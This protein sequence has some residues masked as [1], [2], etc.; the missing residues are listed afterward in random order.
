MTIHPTAVVDSGAEIDGSATIGPYSIVEK[1]AVVG[2]DCVIGPH[3]IISGATTMGAR[4]TV[5][6]F[7]N[8]GTPP[9]DLTYHNEATRLTIGDDNQIRE[10]VSIHRG[11]PGGHGVT[12]IG[13]G[14]LIMAYA[15]I[16]HDCVV[17]NNVILVN[18]VTLGGHVEIGDRATIGGLSAVHQFTRVGD[19]SYIGGMSGISKDVPPYVIM[20]GVRNQMR[21]NGINRI[22]LRRAGFDRDTIKKLI[23]AY[24]IIF[25]TPELLLQE[26]LSKTLDEIPDCEAVAKLVNF[27]KTSIR[28]VVR[29]AGDDDEE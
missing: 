6:S 10:Y 14:N 15:H 12:T 25:R 16:A 5:G 3:A 24:K 21:V 18:G 9:Q 20:S 17:G 27:F 4:N 29:T 2:P 8:I 13:N 11:T 1:G 22:G 28:S 19:Y 26:A 23:Q 7:T